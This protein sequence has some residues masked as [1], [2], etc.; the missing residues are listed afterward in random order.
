MFLYNGGVDGGERGEAV[1]DACVSDNQVKSVDSLVFD[2]A[3][4]VG[5]VDR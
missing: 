4:G 3:H 2:L 5:G 1:A